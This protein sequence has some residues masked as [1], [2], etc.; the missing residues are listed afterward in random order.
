MIYE[1]KNSNKYY[2]LS[3]IQNN[4]RTIEIKEY[5]SDK[6]IDIKDMNT[7]YIV[8]SEKDI[9][10]IKEFYNNECYIS[11]VK[12]FYGYQNTYLYMNK[13]R[14]IS[15]IIVID[16][17]KRT[18]IKE[19][20]LKLEIEYFENWGSKYMIILSNN[21]IY[22]VNINTF[23]IITKYS[24]LLK[25]SIATFTTHFSKKNNFYGLLISSGFQFKLIYK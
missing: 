8:N 17:F 6:T 1:D 15:E 20:K 16:L 13:S 22:I 24:N 19:F 7:K 14:N 10:K 25:N 11:N 4:Y 2:I 18:I 21:L 3:F 9:I 23:Q 12:I 5:N